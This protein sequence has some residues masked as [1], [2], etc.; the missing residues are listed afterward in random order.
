MNK[1]QFPCFFA[2]YVQRISLR[3]ATL[4]FVK[5]PSFMRSSVN[6]KVSL[7]LALPGELAALRVPLVDVLF[8]EAADDL[9]LQE[10][11]LL[12]LPAGLEDDV[13]AELG[14]VV[15]ARLLQ[16]GIQPWRE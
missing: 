14:E 7:T 12:V 4:S 16:A 15:L 10:V 8:L 6:K 1:L 2:F 11:A 3:L 5:W 9:A 13:G